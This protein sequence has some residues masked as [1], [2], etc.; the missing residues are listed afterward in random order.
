[1]SSTY[2]VRDSMTMLRRNLKHM[3]RYPAMT[4]SAV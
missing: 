2:A 4:F 1:M 3:Q